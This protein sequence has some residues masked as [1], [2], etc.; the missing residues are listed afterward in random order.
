MPRKPKKTTQSLKKP[1]EPPKVSRETT[2]AVEAWNPDETALENAAQAL[3]FDN[4]KRVNPGGRP[5]KLTPAVHQVV[6][7]AIRVLGASDLDAA[8]LCGVDSS[9][10][11][12]WKTQG[13]LDEGEGK[14]SIYSRFLKDYRAAGPYFQMVHRLNIR[15]AANG[16]PDT[17]GKPTERRDWRASDRLLEIHDRKKYGK[18]VQLGIEN[19]D[20]NALTERQLENV[21]QGREP[22]PP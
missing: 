19:L 17:D 4:L 5:P 21:S 1:K 2:V 18:R 3:H 11:T 12:H 6:I 8:D 13:E 14:D 7:T 9:S 10:I 22:G 15:E 20:V 16:F